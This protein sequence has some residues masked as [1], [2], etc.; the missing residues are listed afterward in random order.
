MVAC[1]TEWHRNGA[2]LTHP[3]W[4]LL[5]SRCSGR[6]EA[7]A[8]RIRH[9]DGKPA[10]RAPCAG[11]EWAHGGLSALWISDRRPGGTT[12][13]AGRT[14]D[15]PHRRVVGGGVEAGAHRAG[16][17][18]PQTLSDHRP[19]SSWVSMRCLS[20]NGAASILGPPPRL[21]RCRSS[22][23]SSSHP[24][25]SLPPPCRGCSLLPAELEA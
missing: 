20:L 7:R 9:P 22:S 14:S 25:T 19:P 15:D 1:G 12:T 16:Q 17:G 13:H 4:P 10:R 11:D 3:R 23:S 24:S 6:S 18:R 21:P 5:L 8:S 2:L